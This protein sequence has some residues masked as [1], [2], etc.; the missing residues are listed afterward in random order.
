MLNTTRPKIRI[1]KVRRWLFSTGL[2][3]IALVALSGGI[4]AGGWCR[5]DPIVEINGKEVQVW[6]AIP[7]NMQNAVNGPIQVRFERP[8]NAKAKVLYRDSGFNGYGE[9]VTFFDGP[10]A[11][12]DGSMNL[13]VF[14]TVPVDASKLPSGV[15]EVP[16]QLEIITN[17][18]TTVVHGSH[19][20]TAATVQVGG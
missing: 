14:V 5:A 17:R 8:W 13:Q 10:S 12:P 2:A 15:W 16:V 6:V 3:L 9:R 18:G 11:N 1:L 7:A 19:W 4:F 20:W